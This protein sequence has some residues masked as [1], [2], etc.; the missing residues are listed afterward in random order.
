MEISKKTLRGQISVSGA[1]NS[2]LRL[3]AASL[4]TDKKI[5]LENY[6]SQLL[7]IKIHEGMLKKLGKV[8]NNISEMY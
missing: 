3:L 1:K 8:I 2:S 7:D 5:T 4:L 6:P